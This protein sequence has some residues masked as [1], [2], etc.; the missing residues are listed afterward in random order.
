MLKNVAGAKVLKK[1][2]EFICV[3]AEGNQGSIDCDTQGK[4]IVNVVETH[5]AGMPMKVSIT[6]NG[7][8]RTKFELVGPGRMKIIGSD[9]SQLELDTK[10]TL[11]GN[12]IPFPAD[13]L[14]TIFGEADTIMAYKCDNGALAL[15]PQLENVE[16][17]WQQF[18]PVP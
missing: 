1:E 3:V 10:V 8:G 7:K 12:D 11:A 15:K 5:Q 2:G 17:D 6:L 4:P 14:V 9:I 13:K 16:T 18:Q